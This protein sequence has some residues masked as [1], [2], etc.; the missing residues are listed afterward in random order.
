MSASQEYLPDQPSLVYGF[1]KLVRGRGHSLKSSSHGSVA[2]VREG[3]VSLSV[4][5]RPKFA[6]RIPDPRFFDEHGIVRYILF[7]PISGV[8]EGLPN[9]PNA[10][11]P[12]TNK[13]V[14][15]EIAASLLDAG[16]NVPGTFH[17]KHKGVTV[18]AQSVRKSGD[19]YVVE[20][21]EKHGILDG[22]HTYEIIQKNRARMDVSVPED[23]YVKFEILTQIPNDWIA[24]ISGGLN[25]SVQVQAMSLA[26]LAGKFDWLKEVLDDPKY[27]KNIAW[28]EGD[29]G[30]YTA[31]DIIALMTCMNIEQYPN[32]PGNTSHPVVAYEKASKALDAYED[33][34]QQFERM[35]PILQDTL[36]LYE[37]VR[38]EA[39]RLW[40]QS[41]PR[42]GNALAF[43]ER[44]TGRAKTWQFPFIARES[45]HRVMKGAAFPMFAAFRWMVEIDGITAEYRWRGGFD[46]V[47]ERWMEIAPELMEAT[48]ATSND[49][50]RKPDAIGKSRSHWSNLHARVAMRDLQ[51]SAV[52]RPSRRRGRSGKSGA[53]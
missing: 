33:A 49:L 11:T 9:D 25:T 13:Q 3:T 4:V 48:I 2:C 8:P 36:N 15:R 50:G 16:E 32:D 19:N 6:R 31:R 29:P 40:T 46:L 35:A 39:P 20:L 42:R 24:A 51:A 10:R 41:G 45:E 22:G 27:A 18:L 43:V 38:Y 28:Q 44:R 7:V 53:G 17:L 34:P 5:F 37:M 21:G 14:Y 23:Q 52:H 1:P 30:E 47:R 12:N 26:N